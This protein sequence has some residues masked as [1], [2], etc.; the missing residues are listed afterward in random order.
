MKIFLVGFMGCGKSTLGRRLA[1]RLGY[2]FVDLDELFEQKEGTT[3]ANYFVSHGE[4]AFRKEESNI[5]KYTDFSE[6]TIIST[7]GGLP[8]YFDHMD[9]MNANG[10][11]IYIQMPPKALA[12]RLEHGK[13]ERPLL[14]GKHGDDLVA[15]IAD[16]LAERETHYL[17]AGII[18]D[19]LSLTAEK[20][21]E[22][23][24]SS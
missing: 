2:K 19:G 1:A 20:L 7:G 16:K 8:C 23:L 22:I 4:E 17:K 6:Q 3:I 10:K 13:E 5:L 12:N 9:W 14:H 11:V 18:A 15:F 21:E 24:A